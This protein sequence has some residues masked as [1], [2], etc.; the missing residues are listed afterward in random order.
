MRELILR[1]LPNFLPLLVNLVV[2]I[3]LMKYV[4]PTSSTRPHCAFLEF[5]ISNYDLAF[6]NVVLHFL[7]PVALL[8]SHGNNSFFTVLS[9][10]LPLENDSICLFILANDPFSTVSSP[11]GDM[12]QVSY[13][14]NDD[15]QFCNTLLHLLYL[16]V[17][18]QVNSFIWH[19]PIILH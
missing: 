3:F 19:K 10:I 12:W 13:V 4:A 5:L 1:K 6:I 17:T 11:G 9:H 8:V 15:R 7:E 16:I 18:Y 14:T 2:C